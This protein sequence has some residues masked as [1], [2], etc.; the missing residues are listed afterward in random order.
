MGVFTAIV[1]DLNIIHNNHF[2]ILTKKE[3]ETKRR[4]KIYSL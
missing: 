1:K 3:N 2:I 4:Y